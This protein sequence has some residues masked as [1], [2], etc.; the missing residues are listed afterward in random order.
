MGEVA[1]LSVDTE[2]KLVIITRQIDLSVGAVALVK[3]LLT[4]RA[5]LARAAGGLLDGWVLEASD[6]AE[7]GRDHHVATTPFAVDRAF[8]IL[9]FASAS[10]YSLGHGGNDAQKTM[11]IIDDA[12]GRV[13]E[14]ALAH[15]GPVMAGW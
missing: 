10:L 1:H 5:F 7:V 14:M 8:R 13:R 15:L 12:I 2:G 11:G 6:A 9:Q 4:Q 3:S